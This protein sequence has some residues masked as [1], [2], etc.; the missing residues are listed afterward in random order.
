MHNGVFAT[1]DQ[2]ID[3]YGRVSGG[4]RGDAVVQGEA[5]AD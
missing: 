2:V 1:L 3:F 4:G 5:A